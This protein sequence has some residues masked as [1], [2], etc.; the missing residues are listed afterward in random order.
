MLS[1]EGAT[2]VARRVAA[3]PVRTASQ[4]WTTITE[5][6]TEPGTAAHGDLTAITGAAS[7]LI[8][9]EYTHL[10]PIV[11]M[12]ASGPRIRVHTVHGMDE[13][14]EAS[15][16]ESPLYGGRLAAPGWRMSLPCGTADLAAMSAALDGF[17]HIT[18]RDIADGLAVPD[19]L[20]D[21]RLT[22]ATAAPVI[23]LREL[24]RP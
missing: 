19:T 3:T 22:T 17:E 9:E 12:P 14:L 1:S 20:S 2:V 4:T 10:A 18:V 7:I 21:T 15:Q 23:D 11:V 5:L 8:S 6:L 16:Q 24:R 13:A